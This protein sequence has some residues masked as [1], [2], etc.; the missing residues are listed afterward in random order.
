MRLK[1]KRICAIVLVAVFI[2]AMAGVTQASDKKLKIAFIPQLIGIPD[3]NAMED[4]G[5][6]AAE[7]FGV[8]F[9]YIGATIASAPEQVRIMDSLIKQK[10]DAISVSVLDSVSINPVIKKARE[11]GIAVYTSDSDSPGSERQVYVAQAMDDE[12]GYTL[13]DTLV[14]QMGGEGKIGIVSGESTA[15]NLNTWIDFMKERVKEYPDVSIVDVRYTSGG[16]SE[17]AFR[18]AQQ[19]M[20]RYPDL[21]G[22]VAVASTTVP[23]V[24]RAVEAANKIGKVKVIG[25]GSPDT[26]R[27]FVKKGIMEASIL[28]NPRDLGYLT[29]WAGMRLAENKPFEPVNKVPGL[30][31]EIRYYPEQKILLLGAPLIITKDNVD[32]FNF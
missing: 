4:G 7:Q 16:S 5:N 15:T 24:A 1:K 31:E 2:L 26:V 3:F 9:T 10:Y 18:Q 23:G 28:W 14:E 29:V 12:L 27:P 20:V 6:D 21:K 32:D 13:I 30:E 22:L 8:E 11:A 19:L 25:Y 17:D